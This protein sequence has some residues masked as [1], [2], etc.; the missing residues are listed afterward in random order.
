M[1]T[2]WKVVAVGVVAVILIGLAHAVAVWQS[3]RAGPLPHDFAFYLS[4][5]ALGVV[6]LLLIPAFGLFIL[7]RSGTDLPGW[8]SFWTFAYLVYLVHL[9]AMLAIGTGGG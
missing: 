4:T 7:Q 5:N 9:D 1:R 6:I 2:T 3:R 8:L